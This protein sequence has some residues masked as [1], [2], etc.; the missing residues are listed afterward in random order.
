L[1]EHRVAARDV[2]SPSRPELN[3]MTPSTQNGPNY[4]DLSRLVLERARTAREGVELI[5]ELTARHGHSTYGGNSHLIADADEVWVVIEFSGGQGLWAAER[6][7]ADSIRASRPGYI[8]EIPITDSHPDFLYSPNLVTFAV[9]Q[10]W[11]DPKK[12]GLFDANLIYGDGQ[13]RWAGVTWIEDEMT[14]R[15]K[16][17]GKISIEDIVWAIRTPKLTGDT[18]GYGQIVPLG[19]QQHSEL[20]VL[21]HTQIGSLAAP[22]VPIYMGVADVPEEFKQHRYLTA[23]E[24]ARFIDM[25]KPQALSIVPQQIEATRSAAQVFR[26]LLYVMLQNHDV[27]LPEVTS[28]WEGVERKLFG[29]HGGVIRAVEALIAA[30]KTELGLE[31]LT[32]FSQTELLNSLDLAETLADAL[33]ARTRALHGFKPWPT[34][35]PIEQIW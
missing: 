4:S 2:W 32:Y 7:G 21:W 10:G 22:F 6:L 12:S 29:L 31:Y 28:V 35:A 14:A 34:P 15:S 27:Y 13:Y 1:N 3:A 17:P 11:F 16:R 5:G 8:G 18:A 19:R 30:G 26:R 9:E 25:R 33:E 23:G 20:R 24:S